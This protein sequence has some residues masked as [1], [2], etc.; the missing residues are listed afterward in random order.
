MT[1]IENVFVCIAAPLLIA[2]LC[3]GKRYFRY[4]L[5][6]LAGMGV[7]LLSAYI[8]TFFT[9]YYE[10]DVFHATVEIA[11]VI[12]E[13]I[14]LLPLLFYLFVFEPDPREI[15]IAVLMIATG[16]A[17]FENIC[18]LIQNGASNFMFIFFRGFG[19]G[20]MHI[21]NGAI[22]GYGMVYVWQ[23]TWLKLAGTCGL[24]GI[25]IAFHGIYNL[26]VAYGREVQFI[27]YALPVLSMILG[28]R[29]IQRYV[30]SI[31]NE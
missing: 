13:T 25:A 15:N 24:L 19:T 6:C 21:I 7:C 2:F 28:R 22:V 10:T 30:T 1:Y 5:F 17:T 4:F 16:F 11:P 3:M 29:T 18:Y 23:R 14:K 12:E 9:M 27:A 8:N 26:L 20:A 31:A